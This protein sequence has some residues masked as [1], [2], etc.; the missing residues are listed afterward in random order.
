MTSWL[1]WIALPVVL[2]AAFAVASGDNEAK[3]DHFRFGYSFG[4]SCYVPPPPCY[5]PVYRPVYVPH[6]H[7]YWYPRWCW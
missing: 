6:C 7:T 5:A 4:H 1:K 3:A 2:V